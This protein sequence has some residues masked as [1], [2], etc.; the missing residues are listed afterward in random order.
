MIGTSQIQKMSEFYEK[1]FEKAPDMSDGDYR[2]WNLENIFFSIGSHSEVKD[3]AVE[4]QRIILNFET[5]EVKEHFERAVSIGATVIKEPYA[6]EETWIATIADPD[7]NY[8][9][10]MSPWKD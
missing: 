4:P 1:F 8:I 10:F 5:K 6:I 2:G 3:K 7:G 9:Q